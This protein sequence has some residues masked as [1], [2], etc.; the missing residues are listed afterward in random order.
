MEVKQ[1]SILL[2]HYSGWLG[3]VEWGW[4]TLIL[5][6][7]LHAMR[8]V[9]SIMSTLPESLAFPCATPVPWVDARHR[10]LCR[11]PDGPAHGKYEA[12]G[13]Y[14][15]DT[16]QNTNTRH[17][18][19]RHTAKYKHAAF[20]NETRQK[21]NTRY[22]AIKTHG[23]QTPTATWRLGPTCAANLMAWPNGQHFAVCLTVMHGKMF[24]FQF[25]HRGSKY[26]KF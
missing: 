2:V 4:M 5:C 22:S 24:N 8:I 13:K 14:K 18:S 6:G 3:Q 20:F 23:K 17:S 16:R 15:R 10:K 1:I 26:I 25:L 12:H 19:T 11:E 9:V 21:I 7:L